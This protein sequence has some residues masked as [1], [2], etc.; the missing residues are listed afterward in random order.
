MQFLKF[1][2]LYFDT[3][4][5]LAILGL[6]LDEDFTPAFR[7]NFLSEYPKGNEDLLSKFNNFIHSPKQ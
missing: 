6:P 1:L 5:D 3:P 7:K 2:L 4:D